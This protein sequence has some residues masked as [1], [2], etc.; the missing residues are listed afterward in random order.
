MAGV[1]TT[2]LRLPAFFIL[3]KWVF[4]TEGEI[5]FKAY[6]ECFIFSNYQKVIYLKAIKRNIYQLLWIQVESRNIQTLTKIYK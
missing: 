2:G 5:W 6:G 4:S 3:E 1:V